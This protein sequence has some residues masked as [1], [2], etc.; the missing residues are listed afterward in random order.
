M[1]IWK[2]KKD[3]QK[4]VTW[5]KLGPK[6]RGLHTAHRIYKVNK[7]GK[8]SG[9]SSSIAEVHIWGRFGVEV[10]IHELQHVC[11]NWLTVKNIDPKDTKAKGRF[12]TLDSGE[13]MACYSIG[14]MAE[15][16]VRAINKKNLW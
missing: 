4:H 11:I 5:T 3:M 16:A 10:L 15:Q 9:P 1:Y 12:L 8:M 13:E 2:F 6:T 14:Y 7:K